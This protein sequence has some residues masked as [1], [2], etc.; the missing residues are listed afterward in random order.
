MSGGSGG[1]DSSGVEDVGSNADCTGGQA[2]MQSV[3]W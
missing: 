2:H 1:G 3:R